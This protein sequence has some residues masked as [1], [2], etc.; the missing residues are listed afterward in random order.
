MISGGQLLPVFYG[1]DPPY[2]V[3]LAS[4]VRRVLAVNVSPIYVLTDCVLYQIDH[5]VPVFAGGRWSCYVVD[6]DSK[7]VTVLDPNIKLVTTEEISF[8]ETICK[9][10]LL[11][12]LRCIRIV[13]NDKFVSNGVWS[14]KILV[15]TA[16]IMQRAEM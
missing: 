5:M 4:M 12:S 2:P 9:R 3:H 7:I 15:P 6:L 13:K 1:P 10:I 11:E 16:D 8:Q 14:G